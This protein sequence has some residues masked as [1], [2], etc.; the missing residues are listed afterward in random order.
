MVERRYQEHVADRERESLWIN[1]ENTMLKIKLSTAVL[2]PL[3]FT[4]TACS[5]AASGP[6]A[7][8][9][10]SSAADSTQTVTTPATAAGTAGGANTICAKLLPRIQ[11]MI[12]PTLTLVEAQ[13]KKSG[14][15]SCSYGNGNN[16]FTVRLD[17]ARNPLD[18]RELRT[19]T[20]LTGFGDK[21]VTSDEKG[22]NYMHWVDVVRGDTLCQAILGLD[23]EKLVNGDW[24]QAAGRMCEAALAARQSH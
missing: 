21:A 22:G 4:L 5:Q 12:K 9:P 17:D 2:M 13:D 16:R 3:L 7:P 8:T 15:V 19:F 20:P 11:P 14:G 23:S 10:G 18:Q 24:P 1:Q 6:A